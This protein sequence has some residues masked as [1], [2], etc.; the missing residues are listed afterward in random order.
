MPWLIDKAELSK[1]WEDYGQGKIV[2]TYP[3]TYRDDLKPEGDDD[4]GS[5][6]DLLE[7]DDKEMPWDAIIR[8][9]VGTTVEEY[10]RREH[11]RGARFNASEGFV[12]WFQHGSHDHSD[13]WVQNRTRY[14]PD[15]PGDLIDMNG[16]DETPMQKT[17]G[18][19][20]GKYVSKQYSTLFSEYWRDT[21]YDYDHEGDAA[22]WKLAMYWATQK[23]FW[24]IS[25]GI[26]DG[27]RRDDDLDDDVQAAVNSFAEDTI[28]WLS[29]ECH[30][31]ELG[32]DLSVPRLR[33]AAH[34]ITR[35]TIADVEFLGAYPVWDLPATTATARSL[36]DLEDAD[37][38]PDSEVTL[39][40]RGDRPPPVADVWG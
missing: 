37:R 19:Y 30:D 39:A 21:D 32:D 9:C 10:Y 28:V 11:L 23:Q 22:P 17:A 2:D 24:S 31:D 3:L 27:I 13:E 12:C 1:K 14:D 34:K 6:T 18:S 26:R 25:Q 38:D 36:T 7:P 16:D 5:I 29:Q 40:A 35:G 33:R 20:I 4:R 15:D 8:D